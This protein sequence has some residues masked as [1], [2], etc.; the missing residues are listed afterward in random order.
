MLTVVGAGISGIACAA[1]AAARGVPVRIV[2]R[3]RGIGGRMASR[4]LRD[5]GTSWDGRVVDIGASY[6]TARD[7]GFVSVVDRLIARDIVRPWTDAFHVAGPEGVIGVRTGP[8]RYC[9]PHGLRSVVEAMRDDAGV[10]V[11]SQVDVAEVSVHDGVRV[12]GEPTEAVALCMPGPQAHRICAAVP[13]SSLL[14]EPVIAVTMVFD[15]HW[16]HQLDGAFVNDHP[17]ITW[18]ADDGSRRGDDAPV[19]VAHM[20]SVAS[21]MHLDD[22]MTA[23]PGVVAAT[24]RV[25]W[26]TELPTFVDAHRWTY[27]KPASA[28]AEP[29]W[30]HPDL[31]IGVSGDEWA[32]GPR[33]ES[34]WLSG[35]ALGVA[36]ADRLGH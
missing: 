30:L 17:T 24:Q 22:P 20:A 8:M 27:A 14:W 6:F 2:D 33:V 18:I 28:H 13:P 9:A 7:D 5:T 10:S 23:I 26:F 35:T 21:A 34:A 15:E 31:P 29:F 25:L 12:D 36:M 11:T 32:A 1:A 4:T 3:G 16:W 19:L